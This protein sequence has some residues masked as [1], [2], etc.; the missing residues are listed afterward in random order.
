VR[1][2]LNVGVSTGVLRNLSASV[3][4]SA[5][6][7]TP[8][9]IRTG[10]D[11]NAD[12]IFN[13]RPPG[14]GRNTERTAWRW[15]SYAYLTYTIGVGKRTV[16]LPPGIMITSGGAGGYNVATTSGQSAARY[17]VNVM[18]WIQNITNHANYTGF[19]GVMTSPFFKQPTAVDGVRTINLSIGFSF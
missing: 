7:G 3:N 9:T 17:R 15:N 1:H 8:Y 11:D 18:A 6:S 16:P 5:S 13:D 19:S 10:Y 4:L 14:V 12:L 2:R